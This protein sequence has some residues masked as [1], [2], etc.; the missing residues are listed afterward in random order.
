MLTSDAFEYY[1]NH[2]ELKPLN[3]N[4]KN[5][6]AWFCQATFFP[7]FFLHDPSE[8]KVIMALGSELS[9]SYESL[10]HMLKMPTQ[11]LPVSFFGAQAFNTSLR[12][13]SAWAAFG[14]SN[15]FLPKCVVSIHKGQQK[16]LCV[17]SALEL[18]HSIN[19]CYQ[20]AMKSQGALLSL[21]K[22]KLTFHSFSSNKDEWKQQISTIKQHL[23]AKSL[24][25]LVLAREAH[26]SWE[27]SC[28]LYA[29][30]AP[31]FFTKKGYSFIFQPNQE[32][33]FFGESP[34]LLCSWEGN[35]F[36]TEALAG[37]IGRSTHSK[38][39]SDLLNKLLNSS[40]DQHEH[41]VVVD[42]LK[43]SIQ[44]LGA[45]NLKQSQSYLDLFYARHLK[46]SF[47]AQFADANDWYY[48]INLIHPTPAVAGLPVQDSLQ[49][50]KKLENFDRGLY[51]GSVGYLGPQKGF[52]NV[53]IRSARLHQNSLTAYSGAGIVLQSEA[54]PEW[55]ELNLKLS[56]LTQPF[57]LKL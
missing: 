27:A 36:Y 8:Q 17:D 28:G 24:K 38:T 41:Q 51:A 34:E 35:R 29:L 39:D 26:F 52:L 5:P 25:K 3:I 12:D 1:L 40:K 57:G 30:L 18:I 7:K 11:N 49:L 50:I 46:H 20:D 4:I 45:K 33:V 48:L 55:E 32:D 31:V 13:K 2:Y 15:W 53:G 54:E 6:L 16:V 9:V 14:T 43:E 42:F 47:E 21:P 10:K 19:T 22:P 37:T 56:W 44:R 23:Q